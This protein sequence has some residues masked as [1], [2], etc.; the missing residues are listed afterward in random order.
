MTRESMLQD[1]DDTIE[2]HDNGY[3]DL[4]TF[5]MFVTELAQEWSIQISYEKAMKEKEEE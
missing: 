1:I 5:F 2:S 3:I 4:A